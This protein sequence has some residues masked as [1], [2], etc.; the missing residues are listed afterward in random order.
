MSTKK[1]MS[2][3][4]L[5]EYD[6]LI[7]T[8]IAEGDAAVKSYVDTEVAK[9]ASSSH[10]HDD[11]YYTETEVDT[12]IS[13]VNS[14][15]STHTG[16]SDIHVTTTNK[17]NWNS[18]YT[19]STSAHAPS[20]AE[21]NIIVGIQKNGTD[22]TVNSSTRK[23]NITV[24]TTAAEVG[25]ATSDHKHDDLYDAKGA[26][27]GALS[28]AQAYADS[29]ATKVKNDLLNGAGT[30]YDTLKELGEL[31]VDNAD[32]IDALETIA[33]GKADATHSHAIADVSGL[34]SALD[35]K[36][37]SSHGTHVSFDST[38]KPKM[39]GTAAFGT[40]SKVARADHVHPTDTSRASQADLDVLE[41]VVAGKANTTHSH[42]IGD[43]SGLQEAL[44]AKDTAIEAAKTEA[45]N[46]DAVIL[47]EAQQS[48]KTY[49]DTVAAGK[50][51]ATHS[52]AISDVSGLQTALNNKADASHGT[53]VTW[54]TTSPKMNG[55]ASVGS[56]TKVARGDHVHPT[57]TS[58]ASK[59]E[60]DTHVADTTKHITSTERTNWN[61]AKTHADSAHAPSNAQANVIESIKVNG[62]AQTIS[63]KSVNITVPTK[64]SDI[65]AAASSHGH[66]ISEITNLQ[67]TL[68]NAA[69]AI[70]ANT[71][72]ITALTDRTKA[73]EDKVGDGFE[74][75]TSE[76]IRALF[77]N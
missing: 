71:G 56:E 49:T 34:Q 53:H 55:T 36:A 58:R 70:S 25:A 26:A 28:S 46:Q 72:S 45:S 37:A 50:A 76:E 6:G 57:D 68:T 77:A 60:F 75:I 3:E 9:M 39:D 66:E 21:K 52:H 41:G 51:N 30:A 15:I 11:R 10:N 59:T 8:E 54:S 69:N 47:L 42:A 74:E 27:A 18:A 61:A 4:R 35:G 1:Y 63:S 29:A 65:G 19:H 7:K 24:P 14:T 44:D 2:L 22:L 33:S 43:V 62:T 23:V 67:S 5:T 12:K 17:S 64:A 32:A 16:N 31:I 20:N 48:A 38:N 40:S 73:L 13:G